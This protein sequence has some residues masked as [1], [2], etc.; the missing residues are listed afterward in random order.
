VS[1]CNQREKI[2]IGQTATGATNN[3]PE[4]AKNTTS[5]WHLF[6]IRSKNRVFSVA[7]C[8]KRITWK[9]AFFYFYITEQLKK[10]LATFILKIFI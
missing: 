4:K 3:R 9:N 6:S 10:K 2:E 1:Y 5:S 8:R 7:V